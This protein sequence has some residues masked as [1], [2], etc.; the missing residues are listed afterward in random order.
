[1][2]ASA[3]WIAG[4]DFLC[5]WND[6]HH[7]SNGARYSLIARNY[8][9][10]GGDPTPRMDPVF[11]DEPLFEPYLRHPPLLPAL[12]AVSFSVFGEAEWAARLIPLT[13]HAGVIVLLW[14]LAR[15]WLGARVAWLCVMLYAALPM[16]A[17]YGGMVDPQG[18]LVILFVLSSLAAG[19]LWIR[20]DSQVA[21]VAAAMAVGLAALTDWP[22]FYWAGLFPVAMAILA[23]DPALRG[24]RRVWSVPCLGLLL[25]ASYFAF[26]G[27]I[28]S[29][30]P[31]IFERALRTRSAWS[32]IEA[33]VGARELLTG[34]AERWRP[35]FPWAY[36]ALGGLGVLFLVKDSARRMVAGLM[37]L[38]T[39]FGLLHVAFF[40]QGAWVH[41]YWAYLW[42]PPLAILA[43]AG[44]DGIALTI[45]RQPRAAWTLAVVVALGISAHHGREVYERRQREQRFEAFDFAASVQKHTE[46]D[47]VLLTTAPVP[48]F[49]AQL[50]YYLHRR[51]EPPLE[52][53]E[54]LESHWSQASEPLVVLVHLPTLST[55][56]DERL[57]RVLARR[58]RIETGAR[59]HSLWRRLVLPKPVE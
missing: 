50:L 57:L 21:F 27:L 5:P 51:V 30:A 33:G 34:V 52:S 54:A 13:A 55:I 37:G 7:G 10:H 16:S 20:R 44:L 43:G 48:N 49:G 40:P 42:A 46:P 14:W 32:L 2:L 24:R 11:A 6:F 15:R 17:Y 53:L 58:A 38:L 23:R 59:G 4:T 19:E 47:D 9:A 35:Y 3:I 45:T 25:A 41:E 56:R 12:I 39:F 1:M 22:G 28:R 8:L 29:D 31:E 18:S 26:A 36:L